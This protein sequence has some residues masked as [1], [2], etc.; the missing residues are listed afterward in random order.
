M[1]IGDMIGIWQLEELNIVIYL[2]IYYYLVLSQ[3]KPF[4]KRIPTII[5]SGLIEDNGFGIIARTRQE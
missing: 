3:K 4:S 5:K 2:V 1:S